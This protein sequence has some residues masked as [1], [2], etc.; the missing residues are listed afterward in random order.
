VVAFCA[1]SVSASESANEW[2][3]TLLEHTAI[4]SAESKWAP[5]PRNRLEK[6]QQ[7][8]EEKNP[9]YLGSN[10]DQVAYHN[11]DA[12]GSNRDGRAREPSA[13]LGRSKR[14]PRTPPC[15]TADCGPK[16]RGPK[17]V[18]PPEVAPQP[19]PP[20]V[21]ATPQF[22]D[23]PS[24]PNPSLP[25]ASPP[26]ASCQGICDPRE[27]DPIMARVPAPPLGVLD[28]ATVGL[29]GE[30]LSGV[31]KKI[32]N[33]SAWLSAQKE[34]LTKAVEAA[35]TI[36]HEIDLAEFVRGAVA[37]DLDQLK[38]AQDMLST[39]YKANKL[40]WAYKDNKFKVEQIEEKM[41]ELAHAKADVSHKIREAKDEVI[42]LHSTLGPPSQQVQITPTELDD[43]LKFLEDIEPEETYQ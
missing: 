27:T 41:T 2:P 24:P 14:A 1:L 13:R 22:E 8:R 5:T 26:K 43:P 32:E 30:V 11:S 7:A 18:P 20:P 10:Q 17:V 9:L 34:W 39:R 6:L 38:Q 36:R 12:R 29:E 3:A 31:L 21:A 35:A 33:R 23:Y 40:K 25:V 19:I 15:Q 42:V 16:R 28:V 37:S 4:A